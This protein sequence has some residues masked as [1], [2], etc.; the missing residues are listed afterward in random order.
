VK[1]CPKCDNPSYDGAAKCGNCGYKFPKPKQQIEAEKAKKKESG[2]DEDI[3]TILIDNWKLI[4]AILLITVIAISAIVLT[5]SGNNGGIGDNEDN[6]FS[7]S[8]ISFT[9]PLNWKMTNSTSDKDGSTIFKSS[10]GNTIEYYNASAG[11]TSLHD[12]TEQRISNAQY[13]GSSIVHIIPTSVDNSNGTDIVMK[14]TDGSYSRYVSI[15]NNGVFQVLKIDG[16]S[17]DDVNS[18]EI[19][20]V[21]KSIKF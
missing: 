9:Y 21:I 19:N 12:L 10:T 2:D 17:I 4:G 1:K 20:N 16:K 5:G 15:L 18:D 3:K 6:T 7:G 8:G 13:F 11:S 14:N